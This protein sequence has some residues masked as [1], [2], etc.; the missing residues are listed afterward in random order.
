MASDIKAPYTH[1]LVFRLETSHDLKQ[2]NVLL[3]E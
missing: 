1:K 2:L 3:D